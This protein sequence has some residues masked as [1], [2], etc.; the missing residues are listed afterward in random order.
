MT[1]KQRLSLFIVSFAL[2][3]A[4]LL[5]FEL[6]PVIPGMDVPYYHAFNVAAAKGLRFGTEFIS[7]Y[8]PFGYLVLTAPLGD[9][10]KARVLSECILVIGAALTAAA[11]VS[12]A[13]GVGSR[14]R[15]ALLALLVYS[16]A[17]QGAEYRFFAVL[18]LALLVGLQLEGPGAWLALAGAG[19]LAGFSLLIRVS[20]GFGCVASVLLGSL[21]FGGTRRRLRRFVSSLACAGAGFSLGWLASGAALAGARAY[22]A[23]GVELASGYSSAVSNEPADWWKGQLAFLA[24]LA[25]LAGWALGLRTRRNRISSAI[26]ALPILVAWKHASVRADPNHVYFLATFGCFAVV[27][28][29]LD[30]WETRHRRSLLLLA[31][32]ASLLVALATV[33]EWTRMGWL[34]A[35]SARLREPLELSGSRALER[36]ANLAEYRT[37]TREESQEGLRPLR[38]P[39]RLRERIGD[40]TVDVYPW[41]RGYVWANDLNW[42]TRPLP[43]SFSTVTP[44]LDERNARFFESSDH[45]EFIL[46]HGGAKSID[47]RHVFWD[48]PR[49]MRAI[50]AWYDEVAVE[51]DLLLLRVREKP[52]FRAPETIGSATVRWDEWLE[53]PQDQGIVLAAATFDRSAW[54]RIVRTAFREGPVYVTLRLPSGTDMR[55]RFVPDHAASGLWVS[56]FPV[57][58]Q[59]LW[60]LLLGGPAWQV[61][62]IRFEAAGLELSP[63]IRVSWLGVVAEEDRWRKPP[64]Q[65]PLPAGDQPCAGRITSLRMGPDW[66]GGWALSAGGWLREDR[67]V[68]ENR[69]LWLTDDAGRLLPTDVPSMLRRP[70]GS[71]I[72]WAIS[73]GRPPPY[74]VGFLLHGPDGA[75]LASCNRFW[76]PGGGSPT[77]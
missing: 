73:P 64:P 14:A 4:L 21:L 45:P 48:E 30:T 72:W 6:F 68:S 59:D 11:Y 9:L 15:F 32:T 77:P 54:A 52:R 5:R 74:D 63:E 3:A 36:L 43:A 53:V 44:E 1:P 69:E 13:P 19:L 16:L 7:T 27:V 10:W 20:L 42:R 46:W 47:G 66:H 34:G 67:S 70:D 58:G 12:S 33:S 38:L 8:G 71:W 75:W 50:L 76:R 37:V 39:P 17:L 49:T 28:L 56:P 57:R 31:G 51:S 24:W 41:D 25:L 18:V 62:A 26:L 61:A 23:T 2:C 40:S 29:L 65:P 22:L 35:V 55:F 60:A